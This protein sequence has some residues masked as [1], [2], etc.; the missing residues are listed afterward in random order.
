M[1]MHISLLRVSWKIWVL[2]QTHLPLVSLPSL[3][4]TDIPTFRWE[5]G[6]DL[7]CTVIL[8]T[9]LTFSWKFSIFYS[10]TSSV[11]SLSIDFGKSFLAHDLSGPP[12][13]PC[14][15]WGQSPDLATNAV[16]LARGKNSCWT[17]WCQCTGPAFISG[18]L[19]CSWTRYARLLQDFWNCG[20]IGVNCMTLQTFHS[21]VSCVPIPPGNIMTRL[22][23]AVA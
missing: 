19:S 17:W 8:P 16:V 7:G 1:V 11:T 14:S 10:S 20:H 6:T 5:D 15:L 12:S 4:L 9:L 3:T 22:W 13:V 21:T 2:M 18:S 23:G